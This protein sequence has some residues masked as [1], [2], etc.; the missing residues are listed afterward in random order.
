MWGQYHCAFLHAVRSRMNMHIT[1]ILMHVHVMSM[2]DLMHVMNF[3]NECNFFDSYIL[4]I[5]RRFCDR[6]LRSRQNGTHFFVENRF[7]LRLCS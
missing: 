1:K 2:L 7:C 5:D 6:H 4:L 3:F